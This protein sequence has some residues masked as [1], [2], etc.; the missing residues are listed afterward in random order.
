MPDYRLGVLGGM[1]P[2]ATN[3][4]YQFVIDRTDAATDQE[5]VN[6]LI[7]SDSGM[8]DRTGAILGTQEARRAVFQRL[9]AD[10]RLLEGA[11][12]TVIAVPCNTSH[13]FLDDVQKEIS[14]PILH[15]IRETAKALHAQGRT[16]PGILATDGTIQ[17][18]LYQKEF[19]A[20]GIQAV[21]PTPAAQKLVMSL[22]YDDVKAGRDGDPQKFAAV[23]RDLVAQ[24]CDCGVLACTELSVFADKHHLPP[25]YTD[26]MA[27]LAERAVEACGKP[28][29][30]IFMK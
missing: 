18:G 21:V 22:I 26:A 6:A 19:A 16:R 5:H 12:C 3:T 17:T 25:F 27:V 28:L 9:L 15:M 13:F 1:G 20:L 11:G 23:H 2:Q 7:L 24:G 30:T 14:I 10:A 8:P 4:F 29:R